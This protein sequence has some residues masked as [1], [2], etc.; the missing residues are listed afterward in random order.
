MN[1]SRKQRMNTRSSTEAEVLGI[2][3]YA[4]NAIWLINFLESQGYKMESSILFHDNELAI[5]LVTNGKKSSSRRT[6]HIDIK[7]FNT[8][9]KLEERGIR[10]VHCPTDK[11]VADFFTKPLQRKQFHRLRR[12]IMGMDPVSTLNICRLPMPPIGERVGENNPAALSHRP[13]DG[14]GARQKTYAD[15]VRS[16]TVT[17]SS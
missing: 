4:P 10:V 5:R 6:R 2:A 9:D 17:S 15:V 12:I 11:L 1:M 3:D 16:T 13:A 8:K 7:L 14:H